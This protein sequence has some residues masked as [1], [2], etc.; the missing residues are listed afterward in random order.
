M[1]WM[2]R[3][4]GGYGG[5]T[6]LHASKSLKKAYSLTMTSFFCMLS[7][8]L[9]MFC[10]WN[11]D[12]GQYWSREVVASTQPTTVDWRFYNFRVIKTPNDIFLL[13]S[14]TSIDGFCCARVMKYSAGQLKFAS[15]LWHFPRMFGLAGCYHCPQ[16]TIFRQIKSV[17]I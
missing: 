4:Q 3:L 5:N 9:W 17:K 11:Q 10:D 1:G 16:N 6:A 2:R 13:F 15:K 7:D 12:G 14:K 8:K